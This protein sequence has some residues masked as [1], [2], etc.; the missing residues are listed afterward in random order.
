MK[1]GCEE[2]DERIK[3]TIDPF[4]IKNIQTKK[5]QSSLNNTV[6]HSG[7]MTRNETEAFHRPPTIKDDYSPDTSPIKRMGTMKSRP[8]VKETNVGS[9]VASPSPQR[10]QTLKN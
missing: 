9:E 6:E 4:H 7:Q 10:K 5:K 1:K 3:R 2:F 8:S